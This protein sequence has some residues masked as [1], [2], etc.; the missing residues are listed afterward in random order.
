M[1]SLT[2]LILLWANCI[3]SVRFSERQGTRSPSYFVF[4]PILCGQELGKFKQKFSDLVQLFL[5]SVQLGRVALKRSQQQ[6]KA[7]LHSL[8]ELTR[9]ESSQRGNFIQPIAER[10]T[11]TISACGYAARSE[12]NAGTVQRKSPSPPSA[13]TTA[14]RFREDSFKGKPS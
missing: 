3:S 5:A 12:R 13:R 8:I 14:M 6:R 4:E 1:R 2:G 10:P 9:I 7:N 11:K